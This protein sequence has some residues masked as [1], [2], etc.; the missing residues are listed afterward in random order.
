MN[1]RS[2]AEANSSGNGTALAEKMKRLRPKVPIVML[3]GYASL[4]GEGA[5]VDAWVRKG[6]IDPEN[7]IHEVERLIELRNPR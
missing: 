4:P 7:L 3:S 1:T 5:V 2:T 6:E